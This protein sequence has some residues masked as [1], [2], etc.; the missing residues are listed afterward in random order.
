MLVRAFLEKCVNFV[1]LNAKLIGLATELPPSPNCEPHVNNSN[2]CQCRCCCSGATNGNIRRT[3]NIDA[4]NTRWLTEPPLAAAA[5]GSRSS[6]P[7]RPPPVPDATPNNCQLLCGTNRHRLGFIYCAKILLLLFIVAYPAAIFLVKR[8]SPTTSGSSSYFSLFAFI[9]L[10]FHY[11][12]MVAIC[13]LVLLLRSGFRETLLELRALVCSICDSLERGRSLRE[14]GETRGATDNGNINGVWLGKQWRGWIRGRWIDWGLKCGLLG[15]IFVALCWLSINLPTVN[16]DNWIT[17][18]GPSLILILP[19]VMLA[20]LF[21]IF[22]TT[23]LIMEVLLHVL[24]GW[25]RTDCTMIVQE[26]SARVTDERHPQPHRNPSADQ[27]KRTGIWRSRGGG[28]WSSLSKDGRPNGMTPRSPLCTLGQLSICD[29]VGII[30]QYYSRTLQLLKQ[31]NRFHA[32]PVLLMVL[33]CFFNIAVQSFSIYMT[34][35]TNQ[36]SYRPPAAPSNIR[37]NGTYD[38]SSSTGAN[39]GQDEGADAGNGVDHLFIIA[40][41]SAYIL[42]NYCMLYSTIGAVSAHRI[43][44]NIF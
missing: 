35:A 16:A 20:I 41:N 40:I 18:L 33:N 22:F 1:F 34:L 23:C 43:A 26:A 31:L 32:M 21:A 24:N 13:L 27:H 38:Y 15:V 9:T 6:H 37:G 30:I 14:R 3:E 8:C 2:S 25:L 44:V 11:V 42:I 10:Y 36:D 12:L 17:I 39:A 7:P 19:T 29:N 5:M 28:V 4:F